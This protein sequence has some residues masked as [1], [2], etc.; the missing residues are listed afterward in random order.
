M[1]DP[2]Q[3][4]REREWIQRDIPIT[5]YAASLVFTLVQK[6]RFVSTKEHDSIM[7]DPVTNTYRQFSVSPYKK[8]IIDFSME[9]ENKSQATATRDLMELWK[10]HHGTFDETFRPHPLPFSRRNCQSNPNSG[11]PRE[12]PTIKMFLPI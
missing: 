9:F 4:Q 8:S 5:E 10:Q 11:F 6:G 2:Y 1:F 3:S 7:I 12:I